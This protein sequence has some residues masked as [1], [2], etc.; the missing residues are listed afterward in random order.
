MNPTVSPPDTRP[1]EFSKR[2]K[3]P[4]SGELGAS[5]T[6]VFTRVGG[7]FVQLQSTP[8]KLQDVV[9]SELKAPNS[10]QI[11]ELA[12]EEL[13]SP[14]DKKYGLRSNEERTGQ[15]PPKLIT[16]E[17][18]QEARFEPARDSMQQ[19]RLPEQLP[20]RSGNS[21]K[22]TSSGQ[23]VDDEVK[24]ELLKR[25]PLLENTNRSFTAGQPVQQA[26][27][28]ST[29]MASGSK[30]GSPLV[31]VNSGP[32]VDSFKTSELKK[33]SIYRSSKQHVPA[34]VSRALAQIVSQGGGKTTLRLNPRSL[35]Q[36]RIDVQMKQGVVSAQLRA[37]HR[38]AQDL[39]RS[40]IS[41]LRA[42]L[43]KCGVSVERL[44]V[45]DSGSSSDRSESDWE[46]PREERNQDDTRRQIRH[47][48]RLSQGTTLNKSAQNLE[49]LGLNPIHPDSSGT[50]Y[51]N[52]VGVLRLDTVA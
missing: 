28:S 39:L 25:N 9:S 45:V 49:R 47:D 21:G 1:G 46:Q 24:P 4:V 16:R 5:F 22:A 6:T 33:N 44:E 20:R 37:E 23:T 32:K 40:S 34:Q 41:V 3:R 14:S 7:S 51:Q 38:Q 52:E 35:G 17:T 42:A 8:D 36:V 50:V 29:V 13:R 2:K 19:E 18:K 15:N 43:E 12:S 31:G 10:I 26:V 27:R 11:G 30:T 48:I